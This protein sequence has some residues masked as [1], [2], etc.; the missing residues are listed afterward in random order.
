MSLSSDLEAL[1]KNPPAAED[2]VIQKWTDA[3]TNYTPGV[4]PPSTAGTGAVNAFKA[5]LTGFSQANQAATDLENAFKAWAAALAL[6]MITGT[7]TG[8]TPP[9]GQVT[10]SSLFSNPIAN[11]TTR[12]SD[13]AGKVNTWVATGVTT[14]AAGAGPPWAPPP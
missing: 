4:T 2:A 8:S 12:A 9:S 1:F 14:T 6:G 5:A 11:A 10:F 7:I 3:M 13:I